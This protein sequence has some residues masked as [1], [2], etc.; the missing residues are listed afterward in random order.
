MSSTF[1][2]DALL[3]LREHVG[4]V[5][6]LLRLFRPST[7]MR[8][9]FGGSSS[10]SHSARFTKLSSLDAAIGG[11][12]GG[13]IGSRRGCSGQRGLERRE[14]LFVDGQRRR[15]ALDLHGERHRLLRLDWRR[16]RHARF[17]RRLGRGDRLARLRLFGFG[18]GREHRLDV[19]AQLAKRG[20][21]ARVRGRQLEHA[22]VHGA[23]LVELSAAEETLGE[24]EIRVD[25]LRLVV[26]AYGVLDALLVVAHRIRLDANQLVGAAARVGEI[27]LALVAEHRRLELRD[28]ACAIALLEQRFGELTMEI[29]RRGR[30]CDI[31]AQLI[32]ATERRRYRH[33]RRIARLER[34]DRLRLVRGLGLPEQLDRVLLLALPR[35]S[36]CIGA[37]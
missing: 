18:L 29:P 13:E 30:V 5:L 15:C 24:R 26:R 12:A 2:G 7:T 33:G 10:R 23:R 22:T 20:R 16:A 25:E 28:A 27:T 3:E 6:L 4:E 34:H 19:D 32:D 37:N 14:E 1:D 36:A 31:E 35:R 9:F 21:R 11:R 8:V 17:D